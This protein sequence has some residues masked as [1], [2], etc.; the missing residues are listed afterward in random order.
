VQQ[1]RQ[2]LRRA[3]PAQATSLSRR[4][5]SPGL[6]PQAP[7]WLEDLINAAETAASSPVFPVLKRVDE[8]Q[9]TMHGYD[10]PVFVEDMAR[11]V[12]DQLRADPRIAG[13][14]VEAASDESIHNHGAY[15]RVSWPPDR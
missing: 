13:F 3:Q 11:A 10:H 2:R 12:T 5:P 14:T 7:A 6:A 4:S 15:A 8:R 1:S 9:V